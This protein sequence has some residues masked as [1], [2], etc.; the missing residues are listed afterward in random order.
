MPTQ[1]I[2][3]LTKDSSDAQIQA[4]ISDC[5]ATEVHGGM[6]QEQAVAAC[7]SMARKQT[8]GRHAPTKEGGS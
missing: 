7:H 8:G 2:E 6:E 3:R 5:I 1:S 4:S